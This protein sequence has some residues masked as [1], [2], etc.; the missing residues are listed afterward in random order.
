V[1]DQYS[2]IQAAVNAAAPGDTVLV[3]DGTYI[4][5][6][7][8]N[9]D[10]KGKDIEVRSESGDPS[11]CI[12]DLQRSGR[13]FY[14][15]SRETNAAVIAG[16]TIRN[17]SMLLGGGGLCDGAGVTVRNCYF[18]D[19]EATGR[20]SGDGGG[21]LYLARGASRVLDCRFARGRALGTTGY[22][23][24]GAIVVAWGEAD[25]ERCLFEESYVAGVGGA[26]VS[27][28]SF[29]RIFDCEFHRNVSNW[30]SGGLGGA[31]YHGPAEDEPGGSLTLARC[32]FIGNR[33]LNEN[34]HGGAIWISRHYTATITACEF[35]DN[36]SNTYGGAISTDRETT[37][38]VAG[39]T[40]V[41]NVAQL[42]GAIGNR[43]NDSM[44][45]LNCRFIAQR[46]TAAGGAIYNDN[47][48]SVTLVNC[49]L[50]ANAADGTGGAI[51]VDG[52]QAEVFNSILWGNMPNQIR[53]VDPDDVTVQ[54]SDVE[55]G[56]EGAGNIDADPLFIREPS[57]GDD[58]EWGTDDDDYGDLRLAAGSPCIDAADNE[59]LPSDVYDF[60]ED[61]DYDEPLSIDLDGLP[62]FVD[63]PETDDT[64]NGAAPIVDM[65]AY[66]VQ[67]VGAP[68]YRG[69]LDCSGEID[70]GDIDPFVTA[71]INRDDYESQYPDCN[72][73]NGDIDRNGEVNFD[74]IDGFVE[75]IVN[76]GCE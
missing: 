54:Y 30:S 43:A 38:L 68:I 15:H 65:G 16:F 37:V 25:I 42:G 49:S 69:D 60:D 41:G 64:G 47:A 56:W 50:S 61:G 22:N 20:R 55:G 13:A 24:G 71:L 26:L 62:R 1:P 75:C 19:N 39:S 63:D 4:G 8:K 18:E 53:R 14:L 52:G 17:G 11:A 51:Y 6:G 34:A 45:L 29:T 5:S 66:E 12:I 57:P 58:G 2:T 44:E 59:A 21:A 36:V 74:D 35:L 73:L 27:V 72:W 3:A 46:A 76:G 28:E 9:L 40:F 70:F 48:S 10:F 32:R 67:Y 7:N 33:V 23:G 31:V